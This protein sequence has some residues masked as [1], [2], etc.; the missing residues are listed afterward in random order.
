MLWARPLCES[1]ARGRRRSACTSRRIETLQ[2][3]PQPAFCHLPPFPRPSICRGPTRRGPRPFHACARKSLRRNYQLNDNMPA[4]F[5]RSYN[6]AEIHST[7]EVHTKVT[8][9]ADADTGTQAHDST[10]T[11][12]TANKAVNGDEEGVVLPQGITC[13]KGHT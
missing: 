11:D 9:D 8:G 6:D 12:G 10:K 7:I 1:S 2:A 4:A 13:E 5:E 3:R